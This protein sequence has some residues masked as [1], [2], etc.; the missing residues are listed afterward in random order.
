MASSKGQDASQNTP[1]RRPKNRQQLLFEFDMQVSQLRPFSWAVLIFSQRDAHASGQT[2]FDYFI[3]DA[4]PPSTRLLR[5]LKAT[6]IGDLQPEARKRD[7]VLFVRTLDL[8]ISAAGIHNIVED[9][10]GAV[11][12]L[13]LY[14]SHGTARAQKLLSQ[15]ALFAVKEPFFE[16]S[17][18]GSSCLRV[19]HPSDLV[20]L[21]AGTS[22]LP[23]ALRPQSNGGA[24]SALDWKTRGNASYKAGD[25]NAALEAFTQG[26]EVCGPEDVAIHTDLFRNRAIVNTYLKRFDSALADAEAAVI[27]SDDSE[28]EQTRTLNS[29]AYF[30]A[31]R[32]AYELRR[33]QQAEDCFSKAQSLAPTDKDAQRELDRIGE[34]IRE[35]LTGNFDFAKMSG[36][37]SKKH[38]RLDHADFL[39][40]IEIRDA[41]SHGNGLFASRNIGAGELILCE[42]ACC[43]AF[44]SD[45]ARPNFTILDAKSHRQLTGTQAL[46]FFGLVGKLLHAP[47]DARCFFNIYDAGYPFKTPTEPIDDSVP[48]DAFRVQTIVQHNAFGCPTLSTT[49]NEAKKQSNNSAG[50]PSTGLWVTAAYTNHACNGNAMRSFIGDM[51]ILRATRDIAESDEILMPYRLPN[52]DHDATQAELQKIWGFTCDCALCAAERK[53]S[54][55]QRQ[56][57][58]RLVQEIT[59]LLSAN[60]LPTQQLPKDKVVGQFTK[61][62][63]RLE[64][65]YDN[66]ACESKPRLGLVAPGVWLCQIYT[67]KDVGD[68]VLKAAFGV[69]RNLGYVVTVSEGT[70]SI[71]RSH[72]HLV[73]DAI[74]A[75]MFATRAYHHLGQSESAKQMEAFAKGLYETL[76]GEMRG[77]KDHSDVA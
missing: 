58:I 14:N 76:N 22:L 35:Q 33:F 25:Y 63:E 12:R 70:I 67:S 30:R 49:S 47:A 21:T 53:T 31:G 15:D 2:K 77:F 5:E 9:D 54:R 23:D 42:K 37:V 73:G 72:C 8:G 40:N 29:K 51:M 16:I 75:A 62:M 7:A 64:S 65:T 13:V 57:R 3:G 39:S 43:V 61:R 17:A 69:L 52:A 24:G 36:S 59:T 1:G 32:A 20:P 68:D 4:Y 10:A 26:L 28:D 19:D 60:P 50:Y 71:D 11:E 66:Q 38:N 27:A 6:S 18:T 46:L 55:T 45:R 34:R 74:D 56:E 44:D 48:V 41:G